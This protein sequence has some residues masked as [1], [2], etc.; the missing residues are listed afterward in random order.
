MITIETLGSKSTTTFKV[1][2][3]G[4][5]NENITLDDMTKETTIHELRQKN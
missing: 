5:D 3:N 2:V 1:I 4:M